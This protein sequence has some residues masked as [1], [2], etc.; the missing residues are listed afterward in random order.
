[1]G[2][3][4]AGKGGAAKTRTPINGPRQVGSIVEWKG[5]FGW[6]QPLKP[7]AHPKAN[8]AKQGKVYLAAEDVT[9]ELDGV[10]AKVSFQ[11]YFDA[12]GL[13]AADV[14]MAKNA[15]A[16]APAKGAAAAKGATKGKVA[17]SSAVA[18]YRAKVAGNAVAS[19]PAKTKGA[20][21]TVSATAA[22]PVQK[23][24]FQKVSATASKP[25]QKPAF[26]KALQMLQTGNA[27][28]QW[29]PWANLLRAAAPTWL[30]K[31]AAGKGK[32]KEGMGKD[33]K[34]KNGKGKGAS[35]RQV[36]HDTPLLGTIVQWRGKFG[37]VK[38]NDT[39]DHPLANKH[40]GDL[41]CAAQ[42]VEAEIEGV[43]ATVQF[44]LYQDERGLGAQN[45]MPA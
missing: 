4:G 14:K 16:S 43:G 18:N 10:G 2:K 3:G 25:V 41:F 23:P 30:Q 35:A 12:T 44:M 29:G 22:K 24:A 32:G 17:T 38:P 40:Q 31:G 26:Q 37:W 15:A 13:G 33:G 45:V 11:L 5:A 1:M 9:E 42:D 21:K 7:T 27:D 20:G 34:G 8:P 39:I 6:I 36:I 19:T 28:D